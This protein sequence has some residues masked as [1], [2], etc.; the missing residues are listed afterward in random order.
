MI[1][2][3]IVHGD[4]HFGNFLF[5][6]NDDKKRVEITILDFGVTCQLTDKQ[7]KY[8]TTFLKTKNKNKLI[9]FLKEIMINIPESLEIDENSKDTNIIKKILNNDNIILPSNFISLFSTLKIVFELQAECQ[10]LNPDFNKYILG[11]M[12]ENDFY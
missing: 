10:K 9:L 3:K 8:L 12:I 5:N 6:L 4:L 1:K 2:N 11:Y 7:S